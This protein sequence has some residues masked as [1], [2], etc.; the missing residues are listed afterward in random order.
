MKETQETL[1]KEILESLTSQGFLVGVSL[2]SKNLT[3]DAQRKLHRSKRVEQLALHT[4]FLQKNYDKMSSLILD[5]RDLDPTKI[6]PELI[7]VKPESYEAD[8]FLWWNLVWW[9]LPYDKPVGRHLKFLLWDR[10]HNVPF[11]LV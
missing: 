7:E 2:S 4:R 1:R 8:V 3:K 5:G 11:G 6:E 9:S 10:Y